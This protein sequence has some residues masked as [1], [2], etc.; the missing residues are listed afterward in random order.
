MNKWIVTALALVLAGCVQQQYW[1]KPGAGIQQ[2]SADLYDC[3]KTG[4]NAGVAYTGLELESPCM[5]SKGYALQDHPVTA[6]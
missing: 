5:M 1:A 4:I 2:T 3:R 6:P